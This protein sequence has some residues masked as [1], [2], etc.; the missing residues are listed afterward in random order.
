MEDTST[1][2]DTVATAAARLAVI[3]LGLSAGAMLAEGAV[4]VPYW[5]ALPPDGFV[6]WYGDNAA[7]LLR[8]YGPLEIA[9]GLAAIVAAVLYGVRRRAGRRLLTVAAVLSVAVLAAFPLY[10]QEVNASFA[11]ATIS[12]DRVGGELARWGRWH[13][14]RTVIGIAAFAAAVIGAEEANRRA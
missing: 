11:E 13:W 1:L 5:R 12:L 3:L 4:L 2:I 10:F 6:K 14:L 7:L 8:F 9:S